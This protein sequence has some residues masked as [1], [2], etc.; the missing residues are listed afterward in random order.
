MDISEHQIWK[1]VSSFKKPLHLLRLDLARFYA[2]FYPRSIFVGVTG[3]VGKTSTVAA[4]YAVLSKKYPCLV[5]KPNLDTV[6]NL[7]ITILKIKPNIKKVILEMGVEYPGE[8][9]FYLQLVK[10]ATA[11]VT[12]ISYQHSQFLGG[13]DSI[14]KEKGLLVKQLPKNGIAILNYNDPN[15]RELANNTSA[16]VIF[17]GQDRK[18]CHIWA[19]NYK[20]EQ[21]KSSFEIN[22]GV[23]RVE[24]NYD[25]LGEHQMYSALAAT[26]LG[27]SEGMN[28]I[29]IKNA[30]EKVTPPPHRLQPLPG[31]NGSIIIDDTYN[32]SPASV[33]E[34][35][36]TLQMLPASRRIFVFGG[37]R[38]L[39]EYS[40]N[41]HRRIAQKVYKDRIDMVF[42]SQGEVDIV[43]D[44]LLSLG[45]LEERLGVNLT[46]PQIVARL[47]K[48]LSKGDICLIKGARALKLDEVVERVI[49]K[50]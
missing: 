30:L 10:P 21:F 20:I 2:R 45:F 46:N 12:N 15:V 1:G 11:I 38:E 18:N 16:R 14:R 27:L 43:A 24:V 32:S 34:A 19:G 13:L 3:S 33:E 41:L 6:F 7:P 31:Y 35:L 49:K 50:R 48:I 39:G 42:L 25:L 17:Y 26:A 22:Y 5:T 40:E 47:L 23:E 36:D 9:E 4:S 44:E 8:M 28:L 29:S 37:M